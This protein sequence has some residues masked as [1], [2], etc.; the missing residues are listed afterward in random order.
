MERAHLEELRKA[1]EGK[2]LESDLIEGPNVTFLR[3]GHRN[4]EQRP[5][6]VTCREA[7]G[8]LFFVGSFG[9]LI[10]PARHI[11]SAVERIAHRVSAEV[12]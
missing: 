8:E 5:E 1:L 7:E 12:P 4:P 11:E 9:S 2:G 10:A 3:I 6:A